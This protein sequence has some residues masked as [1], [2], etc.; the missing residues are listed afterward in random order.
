MLWYTASQKNPHSAKHAR[1]LAASSVPHSPPLAATTLTTFTSSA[2]GPSLASEM[3]GSAA[4]VAPIACRVVL[5]H[6]R[7]REIKF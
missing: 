4:R 7:T 2:P 1:T 5:S 3:P 6:T